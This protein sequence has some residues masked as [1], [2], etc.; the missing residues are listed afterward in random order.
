MLLCEYRCWNQYG[1]LP[2]LAHCLEGRPDRNLR[3]PVAHIPADQAIH[4]PRRFHVLLRV[5]NCLKLVLCLLKGKQF[6][7]LRLERGVRTVRISFSV[8]PYGVQVDKVLRNLLNRGAHPCLGVGPCLAA[9][10]RYLR[11]LRVGSGILLNQ[12]KLSRQNI[13]VRFSGVLDLHVVL[14][15]PVGEDLLY[16]AV[17]TYS[18]VLMDDIIS[19][20]K[21]CK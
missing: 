9:E 16:T 8:R 17:D 15:D 1:R 2:A 18:V 7:K 3:L 5:S 4:D 6:L 21:F 20:M 13:Q 19:R 10:L 12:V 11:R 14:L